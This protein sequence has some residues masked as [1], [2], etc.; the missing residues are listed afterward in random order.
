M[1]E[2]SFIPCDLYRLTESEVPELG[3]DEYFEGDG[4]SAVEWPSFLEDLPEKHLEIELKS[5][6]E[7]PKKSDHSTS[8]RE[9][10]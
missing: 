5:D 6:G 10:I 3:L 1:E 4:I 7:N 8:G 9:R 2:F